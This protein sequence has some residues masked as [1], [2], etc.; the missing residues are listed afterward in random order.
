MTNAWRSGAGNEA[1]K[2][3]DYFY[4]P[5]FRLLCVL[6]ICAA[7]GI[8]KSRKAKTYHAISDNYN[9]FSHNPI[10]SAVSRRWIQITQGSTRVE[11]FKPPFP[12]ILMTP[13]FPEPFE[14]PLFPNCLSAKIPAIPFF[15]P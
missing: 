8:H 13:V 10:L 7:N 1:G 9:F 14:T 15:W 12:A 4:G 2:S 6:A 5:G 11:V 3:P